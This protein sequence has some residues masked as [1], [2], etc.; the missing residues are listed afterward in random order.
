M[1]EYKRRLTSFEKGMFWKKKIEIKKNKLE[2]LNASWC[3][4]LIT[5][6]SQLWFKSAT[7]YDDEKPTETEG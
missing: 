1:I 3:L 5:P 4:Y 7:Y 2:T 6:G